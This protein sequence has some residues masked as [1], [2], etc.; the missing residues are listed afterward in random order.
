VADYEGSPW[1]WKLFGGAIIGMVTILS[2]TLINVVNN[3]AER[4][5]SE[6]M[7]V[8]QDI[9]SDVRILSNDLDEQKQKLSKIENTSYQESL[10]NLERQ[11]Q[12]IDKGVQDRNERIASMETMV[13][14]V[15][16]QLS[17]ETNSTDYKMLLERVVALE[18]EIK[19][20]KEKSAQV[21]DAAEAKKTALR[22]MM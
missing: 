1:F 13:L 5:R 3:N 11:I 10:A 2:I 9:K 16:E 7:T 22:E 15:K 20:L 12:E 21:Q 6:M 19:Q 17:Q 4:S 18:M 8:I 14:Q